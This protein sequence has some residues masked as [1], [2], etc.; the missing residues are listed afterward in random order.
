MG[1][2]ITI[3]SRIG[4]LVFFILEIINIINNQ[5]T[6]KNT[7]FIR[8]LAVDETEYLFDQQNFDL[9]IKLQYQMPLFKGRNITDTLHKYAY[10]QIRQVEFTFTAEDGQ[11]KYVQKENI[12]KLVKCDE[13][14]FKGEQVVTKN[15]GIREVFKCPEDLKFGLKGNFQSSFLKFLKIEV[16]QCNQD[17]LDAHYQGEQCGSQE[18]IDEIFKNL[19]LYVPTMNNFF[20]ASSYDEIIKKDLTNFYYTTV[21]SN[22]SQS[23]LLKMGQNNAILRDSPIAKNFYNQNITFNTFRPYYNFNTH[24]SQQFAPL[25]VIFLLDEQVVTFERQRYTFF[26]ALARTGGFIGQ[27]ML[28]YD[29]LSLIKGMLNQNRNQAAKMHDKQESEAIKKEQKQKRQQ[30]HYSIDA[31]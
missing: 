21:A 15:L 20:D 31:I 13:T 22:F 29:Q 10:A 14:R 16:H 18:D 8:N 27:L 5:S 4:I 2:A 19:E 30:D 6:I 28:K 24:I 23:Y 26:D 12:F 3:A 17:Y 7:S 9:A 1:G 11:L 25:V